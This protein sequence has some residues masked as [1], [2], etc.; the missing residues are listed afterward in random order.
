MNITAKITNESRTRAKVNNTRIV[1]L[2]IC[3]HNA[4]TLN[5]KSLNL[6]TK[7]RSKWPKEEE[8]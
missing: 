4:K 5:V 8:G 7:T 2:E 3:E 1:E 6:R